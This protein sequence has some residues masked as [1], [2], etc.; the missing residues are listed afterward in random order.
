MSNILPFKKKKPE[1]GNIMCKSN[2][3]KWEIVQAQQFDVKAGK[4]V[5]VERCQRCGKTRNRL[6]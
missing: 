4:L 1:R 5:T 3:H 2:H 6:S